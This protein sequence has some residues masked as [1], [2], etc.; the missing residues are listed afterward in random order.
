MKKSTFIII[1]T[2]VTLIIIGV[3]I[4]NKTNTKQ[5][6]PPD[7]STQ[8]M[9][10]NGMSASDTAAMQ[11]AQKNSDNQGDMIDLTNQTEVSMDIKDFKYEQPNIKIKKGTKVTWT[12][13]DTVRHNV[14][15]EHEGSDQAHNPPTA[16]QVDPNEL[17]GP[18]LAKGESYSFTFKEVNSQPYHC[19]PHPFM[20][21]SV[22]VVD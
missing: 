1:A 12:N 3:V 19:S 11:D 20:K 18:L 6:A 16:D 8:G 2:V 22:T 14:M 15:A 21:G 10:M 7:S 13:R 5:S 17:A 4:A 9:N